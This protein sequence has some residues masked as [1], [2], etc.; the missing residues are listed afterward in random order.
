MSSFFFACAIFVFKAVSL[1]SASFSNRFLLSAANFFILSF[2]F[3][4]ASLSSCIFCFCSCI[5]FLLASACCLILSD[6]ALNFC[7]ITF[8]LFAFSSNFFACSNASFLFSAPIL[9]ACNLSAFAFSIFAFSKAAAVACCLALY[10]AFCL[11]S[12]ASSFAVFKASFNFSAAN[13]FCSIN[14]FAELALRVS[15][16]AL[17]AAIL[18]FICS[19]FFFIA[20]PAAL[21]FPFCFLT[22]A[23]A[24]DKAVFLSRKSFLAAFNAACVLALSANI[25]VF[26]SLISFFK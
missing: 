2:S 22:R 12:F 21:S 15:I 19:S 18:L 13:F 3:S 6:C 17:S 26:C 16:R 11:I 14:F 8:I 4:I 23:F 10:T 5:A 25:L 9:S 20:E 7:C 24:F 1:S